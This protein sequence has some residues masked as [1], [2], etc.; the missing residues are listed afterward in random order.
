MAPRETETWLLL[1]KQHLGWL[2]FELDD[3]SVWCLGQ[4]FET[5]LTG[6]RQTDATAA[7]QEANLLAACVLRRETRVKILMTHRER[8]VYKTVTI[9]KHTYT[10]A[11]NMLV[12]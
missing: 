1:S 8:P 12:I 11:V 5:H 4:P 9:K 3:L 2:T 10:P 6:Q 7:Q